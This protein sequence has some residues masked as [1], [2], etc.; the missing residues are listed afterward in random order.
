M[1]PQA[2][3]SGRSYVIIHL[4]EGWANQASKLAPKPLPEVL[5]IKK[6]KDYRIQYSDYLC[7]RMLLNLISP[8]DHC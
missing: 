3:G 6:D 7:N 2:C 8:K 5:M 1:R 4:L